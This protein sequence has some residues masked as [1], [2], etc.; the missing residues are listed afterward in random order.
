MYPSRSAITRPVR[1]PI[2]EFIIV[3]ASRNVLTAA[4]LPKPTRRIR[5]SKSRQTVMRSAP[6]LVAASAIALAASS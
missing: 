2:V 3:P 1:G 6:I 5:S 4:R